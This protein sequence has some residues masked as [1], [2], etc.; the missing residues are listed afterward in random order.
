MIDYYFFG[1]EFS[2]YLDGFTQSIYNSIKLADNDVLHRVGEYT[3][4]E[5]LWM[6]EFNLDIRDYLSSSLL[7][8]KSKIYY[9]DEDHM[10]DKYYCQVLRYGYTDYNNKRNLMFSMFYN[11]ECNIWNL[12][13]KQVMEYVNI[14]LYDNF[15]IGVKEFIDPLIY[16][17]SEKINRINFY[18][19]IISYID[20]FLNLSYKDFDDFYNTFVSILANSFNINT[21][22]VEEII[23]PIENFRYIYD[24]A[25][26]KGTNEQDYEELV[27]R[28]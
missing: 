14:Y 9:I 10:G 20:N 28:V 21:L 12:V 26:T 24:F 5:K 27:S 18:V 6:K 23:I 2:K 1:D 15:N 19:R 4:L 11:S 8:S 22:R 25:I 13:I 7:N 3:P 16:T 17:F